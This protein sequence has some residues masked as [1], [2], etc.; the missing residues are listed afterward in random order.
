MRF[1]HDPDR[2]KLGMST[3]YGGQAYEI[4][5]AVAWCNERGQSIKQCPNIDLATRLRTEMSD[6]LLK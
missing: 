5:D 4:A 2:K 3:V 1:R 6:D